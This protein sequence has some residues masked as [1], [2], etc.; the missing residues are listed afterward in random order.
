MSAVGAGPSLEQWTWIGFFCLMTGGAT[1]AAFLAWGFCD[2]RAKVVDAL[3]PTP[4]AKLRTFRPIQAAL[5]YKWQLIACAIGIGIGSSA[6]LQS[7]VMHEGHVAARVLVLA[8]GASTSFVVSNDIYWLLAAPSIAYLLPFSPDL[9]IRWNDPARTP[10]IQLLAEGYIL[11]TMLVMLAAVGVTLPGLFG[12]PILGR[13]LSFV[14]VSLLAISLWIGV[15]TQ[16]ALYVVIRRVKL[17]SLAQISKY[18]TSIPHRN[19]LVDID[20]FTSTY[21]SVSLSPGL[22]YGTGVVL[23]YFV[24]VATS[25]FAFFS[26]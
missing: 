25:L 23:Q 12:E 24:A 2:H 6:I 14:Y 3:V 22:P 4:T 20:G 16:F 10:G 5:S 11:S 17:E 18:H 9:R 1:G 21:L 26:K 19:E 15:G 7:G 8:T 13:W